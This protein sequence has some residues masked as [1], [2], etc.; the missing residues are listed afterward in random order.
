[1]ERIFLEFS[2][3]LGSHGYLAREEKDRL[4][5]QVK[6]Y[7]RD[8][9]RGCMLCLN[10]QVSSRSNVPNMVKLSQEFKRIVLSNQTECDQSAFQ[11]ANYIPWAVQKVGPIEGINLIISFFFSL[12]LPEV[13]ILLHLWKVFVFIFPVHCGFGPRVFLNKP[14]ISVLLLNL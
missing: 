4:G 12:S 9:H 10:M 5:S 13:T 7:C 11:C 14:V 8:F 3:K 2:S 1:M 6:S